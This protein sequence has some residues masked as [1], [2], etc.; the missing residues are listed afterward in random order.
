MWKPTW[1]GNAVANGR[2]WTVVEE[3]HG[4]NLGRKNKDHARWMGTAA[5][6]KRRRKGGRS[7]RRGSEKEKG[8]EKKRYLYYWKKSDR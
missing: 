8:Q 1:P 4:G 3:E 6:G 5:R 2:K 7:E